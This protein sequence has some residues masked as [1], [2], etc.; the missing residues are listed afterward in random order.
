MRFPLLR[1]RRNRWSHL[2]GDGGRR[3][4]LDDVCFH[5]RL[6]VCSRRKALKEEREREKGNTFM[7]D[8]RDS[9]IREQRIRARKGTN[10]R[11]GG[12]VYLVLRVRE[13]E[14]LLFALV[15]RLVHAWFSSTRDRVVLFLLVVLS[16]VGIRRRGLQSSSSSSSGVRHLR[17]RVVVVSRSLSSE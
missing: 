8:S 3:W 17:E 5:P 7:S 2:G 15:P 14:H 11:G 12:K 6:G 4:I 16:L 1:V 9:L 13:R 10:K